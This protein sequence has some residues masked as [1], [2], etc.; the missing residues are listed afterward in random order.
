[1]QIQ[2]F[3]GSEV[4][5][6]FVSLYLG[7]GLILLVT[8]WF[9]DIEVRLMSNRLQQNITISTSCFAFPGVFVLNSLEYIIVAF[10]HF[11]Q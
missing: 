11:V 6:E 1:M 10:F 5:S 9:N 2:V 4:L 8:I 3:S 7:R